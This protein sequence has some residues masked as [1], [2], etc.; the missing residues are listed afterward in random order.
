MSAINIEHLDALKTWLD[1]CNIKF[2]EGPAN[3]NWGSIMK[4]INGMGLE[5]FYDEGG[6]LCFEDSQSRTRPWL[7]PPLPVVEVVPAPA[8]AAAAAPPSPRARARRPVRPP[9]RHRGATLAACRRLEERAGH[10]GLR[11]RGW[12]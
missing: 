1:N 4:H 10:A 7:E 3:L 9:T 6:A 12:G 5:I 2:Y 8:T 11:R